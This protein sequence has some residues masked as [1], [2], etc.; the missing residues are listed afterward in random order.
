M[1]WRQFI[2]TWDWYFDVF[3]IEIISRSYIFFQFP[4][5]PTPNLLS[6]QS[7]LLRRD[8]LSISKILKWN[9]LIFFPF[10]NGYSN[11]CSHFWTHSYSQVCK[12]TPKC[13][14]CHI[15]DLSIVHV[16]S[17]RTCYYFYLL[18]GRVIIFI[19]WF[20]SWTFEMLKVMFEKVHY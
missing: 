14:A 20:T 6:M 17:P 15:V 8:V 12:I 16:L 1:F 10:C 18:I 13:H 7:I 2:Y 19:F 4:R 11:L 5:S 3:S 9:F